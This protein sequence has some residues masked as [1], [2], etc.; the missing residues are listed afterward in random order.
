MHKA[1]SATSYYIV[2][3]LGC[4][5]ASTSSFAAPQQ[6]SNLD[7]SEQLTGWHS[8]KDTQVTVTTDSRYVAKTDNPVALVTGESG[9]KMVYQQVTGGAKGQVIMLDAD[10]KAIGV[11]GYA[12][13]VISVLDDLGQVIATQRNYLRGD[14][15]WQHYSIG[16]E[17]LGQPYQMR[18]GAFVVGGGQLAVDN[19]K[20][21]VDEQDISATPLLPVTA[22]PASTDNAFADG[23]GIALAQLNEQQQ[24][25]LSRFV[26]VWGLVK[27]FHTAVAAGQFNMDN[28]FFRMVP[29]LLNAKLDADANA[30]LLEWVNHFGAQPACTADC[31]VADDKAQTAADFSWIK[32]SYLGAELATTLK[33]LVAQHHYA[34]HYYVDFHSAGNVFPSHERSYAQLPLSDAGVRLLT[35]ARWWNIEQY[36]APNREL[37]AIPWQKIPELYIG[38]FAAATT[39]SQWSQAMHSLAAEVKDSHTMLRVKGEGFSQFGQNTVPVTLS[40]IEDHW[41]VS[42]LAPDFATHLQ[43]GDEIVAIDGVAIADKAAQMRRLISASNQS[44]M[45]HL[46]AGYLLNTDAAQLALTLAD[47]HRSVENTVSF[48]QFYRAKYQHEATQPSDKILPNNIGYLNLNTLAPAQVA[49]VMAKYNDTQALIIDVRN[50]PHSV[51]QLADALMPHETACIRFSHPNPKL[52]GEFLFDD[53][54]SVGKENPD[55]YRGRVILLADASS[56]SLAEFTLMA[57][58]RAPKAIVLGSQTSGADGNASAITLPFGDQFVLTGL[59][60]NTPETKQSTQQIGIVPDVYQQPTMADIKAGKDTLL[61]RAQQLALSPEFDALVPS[62][63]QL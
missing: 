7:F 63:V 22:H 11:K 55:Y 52:P 35:L 59:G 30:L 49:A 60:V 26:R 18:I 10:A 42:Q 23:S 40:N 27:Y 58:R 25:N 44:R 3:L 24:A 19:F 38:K 53:P 36:F 13:I 2:L 28:E 37:T 4:M 6:F 8:A 15:D 14:Q 43:L 16:M 39:E 54:M 33:N 5:A 61:E 12:G 21:S 34:E 56:Q 62:K 32:R 45:D 29:K 57:L 47:G 20:I 1:L 41:V 31:V 51:F 48:K 50:Y 9:E 46:L 17:L